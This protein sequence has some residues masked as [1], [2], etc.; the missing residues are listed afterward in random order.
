M[1]R[2]IS[3]LILI[4]FSSFA[5]VAQSGLSSYPSAEATIFLDFDGHFVEGTLWNGGKSFYCAPSGLTSQQITD[6]F[7]RVS[8]DFR[9]FDINV[10]TDS[11]VYLAAPLSKRIRIVITPTSDWYQGVGG[12]SFTRSFT[13]GDGT[14]AFVFPDRLLWSSKIIAECC[15]H[16]AGHTL[17]LSHQ[18]KYNDN[19]GLVAVYNDGLGSGETGWAPVMGNSYNRN[20]S[21]W[22]NGP[23]PNGCYA[24]QDNLSIITSLNGFGYREDDHNDNPRTGATEIALVENQFFT[25]GI[26]TTSTDKDAFELSFSEAGQL[27]LLAKPFSV[28]PN[29]EGANLDVKLTLLNAQFDTVAVFDPKEKLDVSFEM[30]VAPGKYF[31]LLEGASNLYISNYGSL[32]A[33]TISGNFRPMSPMAITQL[34]LRGSTT[35]DE[36]KLV[37]DLICD[38]SIAEQRVQVSYDGKEFRNLSDVSSLARQFNYEPMLA[39]NIYYR[40]KV[41]TVSGHTAYSNVVSLKHANG[42]SPIVVKATMVT[43]NIE[44]NSDRDYQFILSD[45]NGK[46][47]KKGN[48]SGGLNVINIANYTNG[49]YIVQIISNSQKNTHRIVKL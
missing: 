20:F 10:T 31:V 42:M 19:C 14:P 32:G 7:H 39:G 8:E 36:H 47:L 6:V 46:I 43:G 44:I 3:F 37:W 28:G 17:G 24:D 30:V 4:F 5:V 38:E 27:R 45:L 13:W 34:T 49:I 16:E 29:N 40:V 1:K 9:P 35:G 2:A 18:A 21:G 33:Y 26:I 41:T 23:T 25:E 11:T 12:V 22:N 15:S 48:G